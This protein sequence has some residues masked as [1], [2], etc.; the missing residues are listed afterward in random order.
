MLPPLS[1][2]RDRRKKLGWTQKMLASKSGVSQ[3]TIAKI[4]NGRLVPSYEIARKLFEALEMGE[5]KKRNITVKHL[6]TENV[7]I[8]KS[9]DKLDKVIEKMKL[10]AISQIPV[11]DDSGTLIGMITESDIIEAY[12]RYG[13]HISEAIVSEIMSSP[14]PV[15]REDTLIDGVI[16]L[17]KQ[18]PA[19]IVIKEK[20]IKGI[21]TKSDII[22]MGLKAGEKLR[23][24]L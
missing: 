13:K 17:L 22:Y 23:R 7:I 15:I 2:I 11:V 6:M 4:E 3:S 14:P 1:T 16:E 12:D 10:Y 20:E 19:L 5:R 18:Y 21:I 24:K 8:A 9:S